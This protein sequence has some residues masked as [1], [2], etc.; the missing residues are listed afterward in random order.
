MRVKHAFDQAVAARRLEHVA[1]ATQPVG[2]CHGRCRLGPNVLVTPD[3]VWYGGVSVADV[4]EIVDRHV[5][6]GAIV[7]RLR[8]ADPPILTLDTLP[9]T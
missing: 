9:W 6:G 4:E 1:S 5:V 7:D 2:V 3:N 8:T